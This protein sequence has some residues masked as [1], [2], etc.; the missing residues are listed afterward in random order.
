MWIPCRCGSARLTK[1]RAF[2]ACSNGPG[3]AF[4]MGA[5]ARQQN[6]GDHDALPRWEKGIAQ[7]W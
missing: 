5:G 2:T 3:L 1:L 4:Q 6:F 7:F